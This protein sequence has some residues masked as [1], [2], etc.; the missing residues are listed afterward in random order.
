MPNATEKRDLRT[1]TDS[2]LFDHD[3]ET[4]ATPEYGREILRR[5]DTITLR[6]RKAR[7]ELMTG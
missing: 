7:G 2:E 1:L 5:L 6:Q 4:L 3:A